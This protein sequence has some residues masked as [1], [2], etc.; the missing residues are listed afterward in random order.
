MTLTMD[1]R[2]H[3]M[4]TTQLQQLRSL[5]GR[6]IGLALRGGERIDD[7]QLISA[8]GRRVDT[9]WVFSNGGDAFVPIERVVDLWEIVAA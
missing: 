1:G 9:V 6:R 3:R 2:L 5:E 4:A 8:G 7:C